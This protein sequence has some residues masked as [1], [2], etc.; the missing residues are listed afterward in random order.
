MK[1]NAIIATACLLLLA[2]PV[3]AVVT[4]D[5]PSLAAWRCRLPR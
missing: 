2:L 4:S 5:D 1:L 3:I